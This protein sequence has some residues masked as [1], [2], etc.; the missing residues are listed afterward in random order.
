MNDTC[1]IVQARLNSSRFPNK[2]LSRVY[3]DKLALEIVLNACSSVERTDLILA[4]PIDEYDFFDESFDC[5]K[6][7]MTIHG[8]SELNVLKRFFSAVRGEQ[9]KT[10]V[11][12]SSDCVLLRPE[13]IQNTIE[14]Y[15]NN[16]CDYCSNT[17]INRALSEEIYDD[18]SSESLLFD[19]VNVEVFSHDALIKAHKNAESDYDRE[20]VTPWIKR[21]LNCK[22]CDTGVLRIN[23]KLSLDEKSDLKKINMILELYDNELVQFS[24]L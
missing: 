2:I 22:L 8:G 7:N 18:Y 23:G 15:K 14:F 24:K 13:I 17:T 21:N 6:Y 12:I 4:I 3:T 10:I 16:E 1:I 11:R 20:H 5:K 9:Y 19:G